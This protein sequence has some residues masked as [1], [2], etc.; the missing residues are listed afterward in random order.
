MVMLLGH[1]LSFE[2]MQLCL[3]GQTTADETCIELLPRSHAQVEIRYDLTYSYLVA[4]Q[5][6][7]CC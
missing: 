2:P 3:D 6:A 5:S 1:V 7:W 4:N